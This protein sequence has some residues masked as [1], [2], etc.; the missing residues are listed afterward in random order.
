MTATQ[1]IVLGIVQGLGE[2][3]PISSSGHLI[4]VPWLLGWPEHGLAFDVALHLGTLA[5][6]LFAFAGDWLRLLA[7]AARCLRRG[8]PFAEPEAR[9][10][11]LLALA[12]I[13][14]AVAGLLLDQWAETVFRAPALV[15]ATMAVMGAVLLVADRGASPAGPGAEQVT[16]RDATLVGLAQ[17]LAIV[18]GVSRSGST[19]SAGLFLGYRREEAAR[20]SFLLATPITF[21]AAMVKV[22]HF[23]HSAD[24]SVVLPGMA[25]A[26]VFGFLA[27]RLLLAY[28]RGHDYLPFVVYRFAF[29]AVVVAVLI[30]RR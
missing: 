8:A 18:P 17:A 25:T 12:S 19:I 22:P 30:A 29:A 5:A 3:L 4:V 7:S 15:A 11:W 20:F 21:G 28:V 10:L 13:P 23:V 6:V 26:A 16:L 2:F 14:G 1:A 24:L 9:L 27:I